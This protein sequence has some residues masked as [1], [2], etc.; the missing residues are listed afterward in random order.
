MAIDT[1][2]EMA[3]DTDLADEANGLSGRYRR[4]ARK[5]N[6]GVLEFDKITI[7]ENQISE[8]LLE[9]IKEAESL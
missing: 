7:H 9:L 5:K 4:F 6:N 3:S 1:F 2:K 8:A